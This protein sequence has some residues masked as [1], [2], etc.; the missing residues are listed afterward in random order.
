M[1]QIP[2]F[3]FARIPEL[4]FGPAQLSKVPAILKQYGNTVLL[5]TGH[6]FPQ[7]NAFDH[8]TKALEKQVLSFF[9][10]KLHGEPSPDYVDQIVS[11]Y[12][13]KSIES[14]LSIGG[15]SV[16]DAGKAIS[17]MLTKED[18]VYDYLEGVG[19]KSHDGKKL[20][21]IAVPTTSGTGSEA[22]KNAVL[23]KIGE[24]GFKKS[25]RHSAFVPEVAVLDPELMVSCPKDV[26]A[27]CG[28]DALSQLLESYVSTK[29]SPLTDAL[30]YSGI[31]HFKDSY[32][33]A[34]TYGAEDIEERANLAYA[35][36]LSG[37]TLANAGLGI[38]HGLASP[39]GGYFD[40]PHGV[41][42]GTLMAAAN[43]INIEVLKQDSANHKTALRKH[44]EIG[45]LLVGKPLLNDQEILVYCDQLINIL[46]EWTDR[47]GM[48]KLGQFGV[49]QEDLDKIIS[50]T[51]LK[52]NPA[53][54]SSEQ[55]RQILIERL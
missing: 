19:S 49:K 30:A 28:M 41:V 54:L 1:I 44:A 36:F 45:A 42:C 34:C 26:T 6:S 51:G 2:S 10:E 40:V 29:A 20:P 21:F 55:I 43:K 12:K 38:V 27:A 31:K 14:L 22:T 52:N 53:K 7:T 25:I 47:L 50:G 15:G 35:A 5:I 9:H 8:L 17:A 48:P 39:I 11:K 33:P 32:I 24:Q 37:I 4:L 18:S 16:I 23:S 46:Q 3:H 13:G